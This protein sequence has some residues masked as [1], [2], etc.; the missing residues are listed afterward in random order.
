M[1][2]TGWSVLMLQD[3]VMV[4]CTNATWWCLDGV[5]LGCTNATWWCQAGMY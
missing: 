1:M 2:V 3:D 4:G 5:G